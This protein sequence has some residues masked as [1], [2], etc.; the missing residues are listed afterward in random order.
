MSVLLFYSIYQS[1]KRG[2]VNLPSLNSFVARQ[3][4]KMRYVT[5]LKLD[6][7]Q[8]SVYNV[9]CICTNKTETDRFV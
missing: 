7:K 1:L 5:I 2:H 4:V 9:T 3:P 8:R 6:S